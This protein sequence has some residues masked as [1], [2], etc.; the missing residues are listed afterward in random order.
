MKKIYAVLVAMFFTMGMAMTTAQAAPV[1]L[2]PAMNIAVAEDGYFI[3]A[4]SNWYMG[5]DYG[6]SG[7]TNIPG[8]I[9]NSF[10]YFL[11]D[12][13]AIT[14]AGYTADLIANASLNF[15]LRDQ[16][17]GRP[18]TGLGDSFE[19]TVTA[20]SSAHVFDPFAG[21][22]GSVYSGTAV[23]HVHT[24]GV[25]VTQHGVTELVSIDITDIVKGWVAGTYQ[26]FGVQLLKTTTG[27]DNWIYWV[28]SEDSSIQFAGKHPY[29]QVNPVPVPAAL[30]LLGAGLIGIIG[31]RR[32]K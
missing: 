5:R 3:S 12:S 11:F 13:A 6:K 16:S 19:A 31:L 8:M 29:L 27:V 26:N 15:Y 22:L 28:A 7:M 9:I 18:P 1:A 23:T 24:M 17:R 30:W 25:D 10:G 4:I 32:R 21:S 14:D 20:S 2:P